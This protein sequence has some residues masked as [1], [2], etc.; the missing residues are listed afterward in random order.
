ML[1]RTL[2]NYYIGLYFTTL[3]LYLQLNGM[4][5]NKTIFHLKPLIKLDNILERHSNVL[6]FKEGGGYLCC[7][8]NGKG[9]RNRGSDLLNIVIQLSNISCELI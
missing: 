9:E 1:N 2:T 7:G 4:N 3:R 6:N 8:R 5:G